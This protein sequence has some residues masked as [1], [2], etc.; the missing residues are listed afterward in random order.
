MYI[1]PNLSKD[2][3]KDKVTKLLIELQNKKKNQAV[4]S[5]R[6]EFKIEKKGRISKFFSR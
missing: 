6:L 5:L 4:E 1:I 2:K 3:V